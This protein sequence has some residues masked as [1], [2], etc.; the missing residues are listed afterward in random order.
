ML[1]LLTQNN[2]FIVEDRIEYLLRQYEKNN[3]SREELEEL[4]SYINNL[5]SNDLPLKKMVRNIYDDIRKNH[6]SFTY[7]DEEGQLVL[8]E[9]DESGTLSDRTIVTGSAKRK[10]L[11]VVVVSC[12]VGLFSLGWL[13]KKN[14]SNDG[15]VMR[16]IS[17]V[18]T[19][20][21]SDR[22]EQKFF[23]LSDSTQIW[24]NSA[25][26]LEFPDHFSDDK[27][28]VMLAGEGFFR[29]NRSQKSPFI[30]YVGNIVITAPP[31]TALNTKA[32]AEEQNVTISVS[33]GRVILSRNNHRLPTIAQG[34]T[35][36]V[37][38]AD[39]SII[40]KKTPIENIAAWQNGDMLYEKERLADVLADLK[41]VY[42]V[43][44]VLSDANLENK[45][46]TVSFRRDIGIKEALLLICK[47]TN[48]E[49]DGEG[50]KYIIL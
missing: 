28:E 44:I 3:C 35:F 26:S 50:T 11:I 14:L 24:L 4:F 33:E 16:P 46:I 36:I 18:L 5:R 31:G 2:I 49:L 43:G 34:R 23:L 29:V 19:K 40:Q 42:N 39:G 21:F 38:K 6:P 15:Y 48:S 20:K 41:R 12:M 10:L 8:N 25:S 7:V 27:R 9:P 30:I 37:N 32:Y 45:E 17:G 1:L 22:S 47:L 13:V